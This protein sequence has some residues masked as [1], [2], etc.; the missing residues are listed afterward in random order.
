MDDETVERVAQALWQRHYDKLEVSWGKLLDD[1]NSGL[2]RLD[3]QFPETQVHFRETRRAAIAPMS[4]PWQRSETAPT[5]T[6]VRVTGCNGGRAVLYAGD[7]TDDPT[8]NGITGWF[9]YSG[10]FNQYLAPPTH[11]MP[12]PEPPEDKP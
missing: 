3:A 7:Q 6:R 2:W 10:H 8:S 12:I 11:W 9:G 5:D 4:T 1:M